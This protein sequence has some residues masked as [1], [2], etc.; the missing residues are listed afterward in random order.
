[1]A[2]LRS[3]RPFRFAQ[4]WVVLSFGW[5]FDG[6]RAGS[7]ALEFKLQLVSDQA[8]AVTIQKILN[9][10]TQRCKDAARHGRNSMFWM[11]A[12]SE[13]PRRFRAGK[14]FT[15]SF[16]SRASDSGAEATALL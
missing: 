5:H 3:A 11:A 12:G 4:G 1:M 6:R 14:V 16:T 8:K 7:R 9:A 13:A 15:G 2:P 10:K